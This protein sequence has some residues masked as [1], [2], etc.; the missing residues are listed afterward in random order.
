MIF[1]QVSR[2]KCIIIKYGVNVCVCVRH[3][4]RR[5]E[6]EKKVETIMWVFQDE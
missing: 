3:R 2:N 5:R 6:K 1:L 4:E